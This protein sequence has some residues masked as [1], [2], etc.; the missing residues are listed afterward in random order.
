MS[1]ARP[2][3]VRAEPALGAWGR[4]A[5]DR[6]ESV[7][8]DR[9]R[10][11]AQLGLPT[12]RPIVM[13][14]H[15]SGFW[16]PGILTKYI[17]ADAVASAIDGASAAVVV[18]HDPADPLTLHAV[19]DRGGRVS[20][21]EITLGGPSPGSVARLRPA[22]N[23]GSLHAP[24]QDS[25]VIDS[26]R[27]ALVRALEALG[28]SD[29]A[30]SLAVQS[31]RANRELLSRWH[32]VDEFTVTDLARTEAFGR[33]F[34]RCIDDPEGG[35]RAYNRAVRAFPDAGVSMLFAQKREHRWEIPFWLIDAQIGRRPLYHEMV[36]QQL[37][38]RTRLA[39][40]ALG[41]TAILRMEFCD[42]FVHGTGGATYDRITDAWIAAWLGES[43][44]PAVSITADVYRAIPVEADR[45]VT[46]EQRDA[47]VWLAHS[48]A[49]NPGLSG[50]TDAAATKHRYCEQIAAL[51]YASDERRD[52]YVEMHRWLASWRDMHARELDELERRARQ[53]ERG[54]ELRV[55]ESR[56]DWPAFL[57]PPAALDD[58]ASRIV[59]GVGGIS[60]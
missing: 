4:L 57:Y 11:R 47:A 46:E 52:Q 9:R 35:I 33:F 28:R 42:L 37:F 6:F 8:A 56:R 24:T 59:A 30:E 21:S 7:P 2:V 27:N 12:D 13:T 39:P 32:R 54:V 50:D 29:G 25:G 19:R 36:E 10:A 55:L 43:L 38:D 34:E 49:H 40:R 16:H 20:R 53:A 17:A 58:L 1:L 31:A 18:D 44:A 48:A 23:P 15:Q 5:R 45:S 60:C 3:S 41:M 22:A 51:P 14:G 26:D